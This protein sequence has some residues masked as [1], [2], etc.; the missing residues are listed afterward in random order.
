MY[1]DIKTMCLQLL[2]IFKLYAYVVVVLPFGCFLYDESQVESRVLK[3]WHLEQR[4]SSAA[5]KRAQMVRRSILPL[6]FYN[7]YHREHVASTRLSCCTSRLYISMSSALSFSYTHS[8]T[9]RSSDFFLCPHCSIFWCNYNG[10]TL[11]DYHIV[12]LVEFVKLCTQRGINDK[13][14]FIQN[15]Q[16]NLTKRLP[17]IFCF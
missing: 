3:L 15:K 1:L 16:L 17:V 9:C 8:K 4:S 6:I 14:I 12:Y 11:H 13:V 10:K 7:A 2:S 5:A